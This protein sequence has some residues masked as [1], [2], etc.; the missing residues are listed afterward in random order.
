MQFLL[1]GC[2]IYSVSGSVSLEGAVVPGAG[3]EPAR[4][5]RPNGF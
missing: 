1:K 2:K 4:A 3:F 5:F